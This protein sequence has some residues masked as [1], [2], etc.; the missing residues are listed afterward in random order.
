M[1]GFRTLGG[2]P[3][4][5]ALD[6]GFFDPNKKYPLTEEG[7]ILGASVFEEPDTNRLAR[8]EGLTGASIVQQKIDTIRI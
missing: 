1:D 2:I 7:E 8:N 5:P 6:V 4:D 3:L